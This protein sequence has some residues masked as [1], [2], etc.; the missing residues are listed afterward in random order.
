MDVKEL[1]GMGGHAAVK[2]GLRFLINTDRAQD[3][4]VFKWMNMS[5]APNLA[6]RMINSPDKFPE[7]FKMMVD[8]GACASIL[9]SFEDLGNVGNTPD[10]DVV[11]YPVAMGM[12]ARG[13]QARE[14][15]LLAL[16][17]EGKEEKT[18][19]VKTG[20]GVYEHCL[21]EVDFEPRKQSATQSRVVFQKWMNDLFYG[22]C[23]ALCLMIIVIALSGGA[24]PS[25][26]SGRTAEES[27]NHGGRSIPQTSRTE[28]GLKPLAPVAGAGD[29]RVQMTERSGQ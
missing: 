28:G 11:D 3:Y 23:G 8:D 16:L 24:V 2:Y 10:V 9:M 21:N 5:D 19:L 6:R 27:L 22:V 4:E 13:Q 15:N 29:S 25:D 18:P 17:G 14:M 26:S 20:Q 12:Y 7:G 1:I